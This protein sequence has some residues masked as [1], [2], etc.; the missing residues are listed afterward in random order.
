[1]KLLDRLFGRRKSNHFLFQGREAFNKSVSHAL[2]GIEYAVNHERNIK[3]QIV[4]AILVLVFGF[5]FKVSIIEWLVLLLVIAMVLVLELVN[6][7]I[8]R[9]ID[10]VTDDYHDLAKASKDVAAGA[11]LVMSLFSVIIGIV[12]FLP[13][14]IDLFK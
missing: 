1:M 7:A 5:L 6:T 13:R 9:A 10:L 11:V 12:I 2:S 4:F 14:I 8:E 3:I